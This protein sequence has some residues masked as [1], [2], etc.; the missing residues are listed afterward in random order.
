[1]TTATKKSRKSEKPGGVTGIITNT[2]EKTMG[3]GEKISVATLNMPYLFLETVGVDEEKTAG[4]KGF[5][6]KVVGGVYSGTDWM[7][8][9]SANVSLAPLRFVGK[10]ISK[11]TGGKAKTKAAKKEA[12]KAAPK[13]V[14]KKPAAKKAAPKKAK[15]AVG[16]KKAPARKKAPPRIAAKAPTKLAA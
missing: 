12:K 1:M 16:V 4:V 14:A 6:A 8:R 5:N 11:L 2:Y 10:G 3:F 15:R 9:K 7:A 13:K